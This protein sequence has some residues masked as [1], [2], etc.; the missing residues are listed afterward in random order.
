MSSNAPAGKSIDNSLPQIF[1]ARLGSPETLEE[2][3]ELDD[4]TRC[5]IESIASVAD[6]ADKL[7]VV[8][9]VDVVDPLVGTL[10]KPVQWNKD[11]VI[12]KN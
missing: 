4:A 12:T 6:N 5:K 2:F 11:I 3:I 1:P 7:I 9:I 10:Y 8:C